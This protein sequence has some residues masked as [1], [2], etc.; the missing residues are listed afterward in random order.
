MKIKLEDCV[1]F[2]DEKR[3]PLSANERATL[4][5]V[6]PYYGAQGIIDYVDDYLFDGEYILVAEDGNNL[7]AVNEPIATWATGKFWVNNHAHILGAKKGY[8][9]RYV[10]YL[11]NS[12]N[13]RGLITGSAQPKLN[14]QNLRKLVLRLPDKNAQDEIASFLTSIDNQIGNGKIIIRTLKNLIKQIYGYWFV[15]FE[16]PDKSERPYKSN[17]GKMIWNESI[18]RWIPEGWEVKRINQLMTIHTE[19]VTPKDNLEIGWEYYSIPAFDKN[20]FPAF[21]SGAKIASNKYKVPNDSILISKLNPQF[22]R[23][24]RPLHLSK[25]GICSTEFV[26]LVPNYKEELGYCYSLLDSKRFQKYLSQNA[27]SSTGSRSRIPPDVLV[28]FQE[29][30]PPKELRERFEKIIGPL[31]QMEDKIYKENVE[32]AHL[33]DFLLPLLMNGQ[34]TF[35]EKEA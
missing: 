35:K 10:Y 27:S 14:Q 9:L 28:K 34:I 29:A 19:S 7:K 15:Q 26:V 3:V 16:S 21:E 2:L 22:K 20:H 12:M 11:L 25:N 30:I 24:W 6:Y 23:L 32:L 1:E 13:L 31:F 5:K 18:N 4:E 17:G 33:K 8:N